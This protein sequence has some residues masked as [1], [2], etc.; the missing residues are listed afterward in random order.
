[1]AKQVKLSATR[2]T[3]TG[4]S[5]VR[6]IKAQGAVPAIIY[7]GKDKAEA[8]QVSKRDISL[9]LSHASGENILVE[10]EIEGEKAGRLALVQEVQHAPLG[11]DILHV[12][13]HAISID[14]MI[15]ADVPLE[16]TG[17]AEGVKT[18]GGL[19]EQALRSL[20]IEC[21]PKDLPDVITVDVSH[22]NIGDAIHVREIPLP[23]GVTTRVPADLT[24]FSVLAPTVEEEP[25]AA[26]VAAGPE[27]ITAKKEEGEATVPA[28]GRPTREREGSE[29]VISGLRAG[30]DV[31]EA[32]APIRLIA[33]L[34]NPGREYQRTRHNIGFMVLDRLAADAQLPWDYSEKWSAGW[35]KSDVIMVKPATFMNRS[36]EA[37]AAIANFYKIAA[38]E[39]LV[40]LDDLALPLGRLR[41]RAQGSSGGHNGLESVFEHF[42]TEA[43]PRLRVGI[44][45]AP[46]R[47]AVDYV[48]G[49]FFDEEKPVLDE[50]IERAAEA[51]KCAV[52]KG[53][54]AAMN[55][56]NKPSEL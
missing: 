40:V 39:I 42:G 4:R 17:T 41:L 49:R 13:F 16:P 37:V 20:E 23:Q 25:V 56:F 55:V 1:M 24:A 10:L 48:L 28:A 33:G 3:G 6:K 27:V 29:E 38:A 14:E 32:A 52:D 51:A 2:R 43:V 12:D 45:A 35:A 8:L 50:A 7:G 31:N 26:E 19:L 21:L 34:G 46:S 9:M 15:E 53:L 30:A 36:G 22:L 54:F 44:G 47:G 11:G 18:F 5:A